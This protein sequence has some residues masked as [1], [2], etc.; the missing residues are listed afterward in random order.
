MKLNG[1]MLSTSVYL[2]RQS[3][4]QKCFRKWQW[5]HCV[6]RQF[7]VIFQIAVAMHNLAKTKCVIT[8]FTGVLQT[9][10]FSSKLMCLTLMVV[11][12]SV[13]N[14]LFVC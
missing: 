2:R 6:L 10:L 12:E 14:A 9:Q 13:V 7:I 5:L 1:I 8:A 4:S 3:L 11:Y